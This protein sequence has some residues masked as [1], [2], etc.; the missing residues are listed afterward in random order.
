MPTQ[1]M[2]LL[3]LNCRTQI[4]QNGSI[5]NRRKPELIWCVPKLYACLCYRTKN[6]F[7]YVRTREC[8]SHHPTTEINRKPIQFTANKEADCVCVCNW[9]IV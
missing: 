7:I 6:A 4:A 1:N 5:G 8:A 2:E 3:R 9:A